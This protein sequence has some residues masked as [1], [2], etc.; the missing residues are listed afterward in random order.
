MLAVGDERWDEIFGVYRYSPDPLRPVTAK[1][2]ERVL[3]LSDSKELRWAKE[4][5][6]SSTVPLIPDT[7]ADG[8]SVAAAETRI[9]W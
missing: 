9:Q 7:L 1:M 3:A 6:S 8:A 5:I 4:A 2:W